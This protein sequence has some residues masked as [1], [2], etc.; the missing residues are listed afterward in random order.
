MWTVNIR[1]PSTAPL[2][3]IIK[4]GKNSMGRKPDNDIVIA[5]DS[6]SR[7]HAEIYYLDGVLVIQDLKSTNGTYVNR[8]RI[9]GPT[10]LHDNDVI[11]IGKHEARVI[12]REEGDGSALINALSGTRPLTKD[13]VLEA[14]D[15]NAVLLY[16]VANRL[17][18][19]L[20]L[21]LAIQEISKLM[22]ISMGADK[23]EII[24][25]DHFEQLEELGFPT[26][27]AH[28]AIDQRSVVII[29]DLASEVNH[30][31]SKSA[32]LLQIRSILCV[33]VLIEGAVA[34][35]IYVYKTDPSARPFDQD[36]VQTG[37]A[38]SYQTALTIQRAQLLERSLILEQKV[39][40]DFLT[41][42]FSREYFL[43]LAEHEFQRARRFGHVLTIA[44]LDID[45]LKQVNDK[46]GHLAGDHMLKEIAA[47]S[48]RNIRDIDL[49][50]RYG[51]DE[52]IILLIETEETNARKVATRIRDS[53][54]GSPIETDQG[55]LSITVSIG[56]ATLN[57]TYTNLTEIID[58]ADNALYQAKRGGRNL[59]EITK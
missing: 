38:I 41:G 43:E 58:D 2:E 10:T 39:K 36:D 15:Q 30:A 23:C 48:K 3:F 16:E 35:L 14:V 53:I 55:Q 56:L 52:F 6:A 57:Q 42:L 13:L 25:A 20:D 40:T 54:A 34:A 17:T 37:V 31:P 21:P 27:I 4:P 51:G 9:N 11:R 49:I 47:R 44:M 1:S 28:E 5:D 8:E 7:V 12:S 29:P 50:G 26:S 24:L 59:V 32:T 22:Q 18:T 45:L 19:I 33:P 46:Y